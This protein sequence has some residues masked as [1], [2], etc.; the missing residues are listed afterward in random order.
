MLVDL[1]A[2]Y[3]MHV[4]PGGDTH[5]LLTSWPAQQVRAKIVDLVSRLANYEGPGG[6][7][8][9]TVPLLRE[10]D[11]GVAL[12]VAFNPWTE[13]DPSRHYDDPPKDDYFDLLLEVLDAVDAEV[14]ARDD[15]EIVRTAEALD[16]CLAEDRVALIHAVEG[17]VQ[18]GSAAAVPAN[19]EELARRG[20]AYVTVAHLFWRQVATVVPALPF[21]PDRV[22]RLLFRQ[23]RDMGLGPS[24]R[25]AVQAMAR[26]GVL[27]DVT[28][29]SD[30]SVRETLALLDEANPA[31]RLPVIASHMACRFGSLAY[32]M[33]DD[34]IRQVADRGGVLGVIACRHYM[35]DGLQQ[36]ETWEDTVDITCAHAERI[37][38]VTG[39]WDHAAIGSD[40]DGYIKPALPGLEHE[41]RM[42]ELQVALRARLGAERAEKV[43][44]AN[45]LRVLRARFAA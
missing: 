4:V 33:T 20:V 14:G 31:R 9:V 16:R 6:E 15:A 29:M 30:A 42:R 13:L 24:G 39:S 27:V 12:S 19:V 36:A 35:A 25:A 44:S 1:H 37:A 23:P 34:A 22:Y 45:A 38:A 32:N 7:P 26:H 10:G 21:L 8:G 28:H 40:L 41:G 3:P 11:V 2:H 43:I 18:L 17:A 5:E